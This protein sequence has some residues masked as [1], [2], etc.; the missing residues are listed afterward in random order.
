MP[1]ALPALSSREEKSVVYPNPATNDINIVFDE[2]ADVKNI[3]LYNVI[4][5]VMNVYKVSGNSANLNIE[6]LPSGI[7]FVK[8]Y[9]ANG[10]V[11]VTRKFTKQ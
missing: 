11:V 9:S 1:A 6:N 4:G 7:Y 5:K 10:S 8:L 2:N 3:A